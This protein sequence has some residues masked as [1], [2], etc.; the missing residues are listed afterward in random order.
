MSCASSD[1]SF[2]RNASIVP[3]A[4]QANPDISGIGVPKFQCLP[5]AVFVADVSKGPHWLRRNGIH[6]IHA[7]CFAI[8]HGVT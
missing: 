7:A 5:P 3:A 2:L 1:C 4:L 8:H 6:N